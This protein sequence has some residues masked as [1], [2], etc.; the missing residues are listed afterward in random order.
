[1]VDYPLRTAAISACFAAFIALLAA[2]RRPV[3]REDDQL[4]PARHIVIR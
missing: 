2:R 4:R 1:L 3:L